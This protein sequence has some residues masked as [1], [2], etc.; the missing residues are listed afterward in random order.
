MRFANV[1]E[2]GFPLSDEYLIRDGGP[3]ANDAS[4]DRHRP[5]QGFLPQR[6]CW[7]V[8]HGATVESSNA[9]NPA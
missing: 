3:V 5:R 8:L 4:S 7:A 6:L 9:A 2:P 1:E